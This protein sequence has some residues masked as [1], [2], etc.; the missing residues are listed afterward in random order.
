M[1]RCVGRSVTDVTGVT[2]EALTSQAPTSQCSACQLLVLVSGVAGKRVTLGSFTHQR[3]GQPSHPATVVI[4]HKSQ[5]S[6]SSSD[7]HPQPP[8]VRA[9]LC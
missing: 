3:G 2:L 6:T 9:Q 8:W 4:G 5:V 7:A 1:Q